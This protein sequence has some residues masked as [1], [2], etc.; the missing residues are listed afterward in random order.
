MLVRVWCKGVCVREVAWGRG[1][2]LVLMDVV[3]T[4]ADGEDDAHDGGI[5]SKG[6]KGGPGWTGSG[7]SP[8][9]A[10]GEARG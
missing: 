5:Q 3:D 9:S 8:R 10:E 1:A 7:C 4:A 6:R 2:V